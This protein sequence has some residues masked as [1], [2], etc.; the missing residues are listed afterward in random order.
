MAPFAAILDLQSGSVTLDLAGTTL[1]TEVTANYPDDGKAKAAKT[2]VDNGLNAIKGLMMFAGGAKGGNDP[3]AKMMEQL[4]KTL[5]SLKVEQKGS[6]VVLQVASDINPADFN[7][8]MLAMMGGGMRPGPGPMQGP[9]PK[10]GPGPGPGVG[11]DPTGA[12]KD[13][14]TSNNLKQLMLA[15]LNYASTHNGKLPT[16]IM[17][18]NGQPLLSWRVALLPYLEQDALF[19]QFR[20]NEPWNS[21]TNSR[22]W[23]KMPKVFA[24]P[25]SPPGNSFTHYKVF[26]GPD[27]HFPKP[28]QASP[29]PAGF[30]KGT[31]NTLLI[32]EDKIAT[33]W[34]KPEDISFRKGTGFS[35]SNLGIPGSRSVHGAM[36]DGSVRTLKPS[37]SPKT[38][39]AVITANDMDMP[40]PDW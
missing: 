4:K 18:P 29:Y 34:S 17:G 16:D 19:K 32:V 26:T 5:D 1:Q 27:T 25:G 28:G 31:S 39:Q 36:A 37:I 40:G 11:F 6:D 10:I 33:V 30:R 13:V 14:T 8:A 24:A 22:L 2:A 20:L 7:P 23:S 21:P 38:L 15:F 9:G 12:A 35:V 3:Q